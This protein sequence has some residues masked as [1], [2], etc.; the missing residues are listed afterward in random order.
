MSSEAVQTGLVPVHTVEFPGGQVLTVEIDGEPYVVLRP[1]IEV[2]GL[3]YSGQL[4]RLRRQSWATVC[5]TH[6]V[7]ADGKAREMAVV[8]VGTFLMLLA[9]ID[10][11]RVSE[12]CRP[13]LIAYQRETE[14]A[15]RDYWTRGAAINPRAT[16]EQL[17]RLI[18]LCTKQAGVLRALEG[19]VDAAW[20]EAK[21][22]HLAALALGEEPEI[23]P[24]RRPLTVSV[25]LGERGI[26]G[27]QLRSLAPTFGKWLKAE[28]R[29][30]HGRNPKPTRRWVDGAERDVCGYKEADRP[31]F[32]L[33]WSTRFAAR[34]DD[35]SV[36]EPPVLRLPGV[37]PGG[38]GWPT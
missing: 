21:A 4:Q 28:Y 22:R 14:R 26:R 5:I 37:P 19:I 20:L 13:V 2:L 1:A 17:D 30:Q 27:A 29:A 36:V 11:S 16:T 15:V 31:L 32:D 23:D 35:G 7:G 33:V 10:E 18:D 34:G 24:V 9:T 8:N 6:T 38:E 12:E 25:Y 3:N